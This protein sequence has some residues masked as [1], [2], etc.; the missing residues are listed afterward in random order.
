MTDKGK[1]EMKRK[2][3][4]LF[5]LLFV[6][7]FVVVAEKHAQ[8]IQDETATR[9]TS[10]INGLLTATIDKIGNS[11][12]SVVANIGKPLSIS[13]ELVANPNKPLQDDRIH[14]LIYDGIIIWIYQTTGNNK[15]KLL[16]VRFTKNRKDIFPDLIGKSEEYIISTFG[17]PTSISEGRNRYD[18]TDDDESALGFIELEFKNSSVDAVELTYY[19]DRSNA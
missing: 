16:S 3:S 18:L 8:A 13:T 7:S 19:I 11:R 9:Y 15:E 5:I 17:Q 6:M 12:S 10:I 4:M 14:I 2:F 1:L